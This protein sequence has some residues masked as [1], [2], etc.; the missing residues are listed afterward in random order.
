MKTGIL[1]G[2]KFEGVIL[3]TVKRGFP[4]GGGLL[5]HFGS[6]VAN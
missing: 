5:V 4:L 1:K 6:E 3:Y 2:Q